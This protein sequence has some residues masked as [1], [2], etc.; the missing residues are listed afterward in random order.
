MMYFYLK[1]KNARE[2]IQQE[3]LAA[4]GKG[5]VEDLTLSQLNELPKL[6]NFIKETLRLDPPSNFSLP[7]SAKERL[8]ICGVEIPKGTTLIV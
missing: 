2:E 6:N 5:R 7:Y 3:L 8:T 1:N 4:V